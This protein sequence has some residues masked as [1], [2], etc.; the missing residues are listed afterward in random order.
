VAPLHS[1]VYLRS[2]AASD[3]AAFDLLE[4]KLAIPP[5]GPGTVT[6]PGLVNRLRAARDRRLVTLVA[7]AGY[8]KTTLLSQWAE[9]DDRPFA[10]V[11]IDEGDD[12]PAVLLRYAAAAL[13]MVEP[14]EDA[15]LDTA[16][17][18]SS[19]VA[20][21]SG[22]IVIVLDDVQLVR[23]PDSVA[24]I[25]T[26]ARHVPVGST[27]ALSGR[28]LPELRV[29][30]QR[31]SGR[32]F[33]LGPEELALGRR[34]A[35]LLLHAAGLELDDSD[36]AELTERTEG[37]AAGLHL[38]GLVLRSGPKRRPVAEF[39]GDD[40]FVAD[41]F[42][43][44]H[45]ARLGPADVRFLTRSSVLDS[46]CGPL[47]DAVLGRRQGST[48]KLE[49]LERA[50]LFVVP[51]DRRRGWY[52][53]HHLFRD[54]LKS[55]LERREPD[56]VPELNR[57]A[58]AWCE[59]NDAPEEARR[60]AAAAGDLD[61][62]ARLVTKHALPTL[63][64]GRVTILDG[65]FDCFGDPAVL[66]RYPR[67]AVVGSW[68]HALSGRAHKAALWLEAA[69]HGTGQ[70]SQASIALLRAAFCRDGVDQMLA[71]AEAADVGLGWSSPWRP[72][73]VL[74]RGVAHLL[75]GED[76]AADALLAEAAELA[77]TVGAADARRLAL[78]ERSLLA[79]AAGDQARARELAAA[80]LSLGGA[81]RRGPYVTSA[82]TLAAVVRSEL[83]TGTWQQARA[84][85][86]EADQLLSTLTHALPW[87]AVQTSL[88]LAR[89]HMAMLDTTAAA[90]FVGNAESVLERRPELGV[91]SSEARS[92][93]AELDALRAQN[94][95]RESML[96]A[97]ELRLVPLLDTRLS[98][99]EIGERLHVSRNTVKTQAIAVYRK[100]GV[101][102][103]NEAID[104]AADLGL[105]HS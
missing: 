31:A 51:L 9:R 53:Y 5:A 38:A 52:R 28:A 90:T 3:V 32:L 78:A 65:W 76:V 60:Y 56:L 87:C 67:V 80:A 27:L 102:S 19:A 95:R 55:E 94:G 18:M 49:S 69:E 7:P 88:E 50:S 48:E 93:R 92:V 11:T 30:R 8:G 12:D 15:A 4:A 22:P 61:S 46:M 13:Q 89:A 41:Y 54:M 79:T 68:I 66:Q 99:R 104:R 98:F 103:R 16:A 35:K 24:L 85:L 73:A 25:A 75:R 96:T 100:L 91:L 21:A 81:G 84:A 10:W 37:W 63:A 86:A 77:E 97:A 45:L 2:A 82:I 33:E 62:V 34:E 29:A 20:R 101:S 40:R 72:T 23:S 17:R 6:R 70:R 42:R 36:L 43:F 57:R 58:A 47:C 74:L 59:A 39:R 14:L 1:V 64:A 83:P 26:L 71:D 44:E 105:I